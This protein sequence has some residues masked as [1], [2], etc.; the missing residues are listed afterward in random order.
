[1]ALLYNIMYAGGFF[2]KEDIRKLHVSNIGLSMNM[3]M[4]A[5]GIIILKA[6]NTPS[7]S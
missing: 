3:I 5:H 6:H 7:L 2:A 1:M 4:Y